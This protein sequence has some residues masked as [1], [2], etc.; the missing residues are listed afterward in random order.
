MWISSTARLAIHAVLRIS[1]AEEHRLVSVEEVAA[2]IGCP[3]NY[4][5]KT[6]Y[7]LAQAGILRSE[8]GRGGGFQLAGRADRL[9]LARIIEPFEPA[10][11]RRCLLGRPMC[12]DA[13]PCPA[14]ERWK[15]VAER[16]KAFFQTT[17]IA[18]LQR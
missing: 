14:H 12:G 3:R 4:L 15:L 2:A 6:L 13:D 5:S 1:E 7:A 18:Q 11:E 17:T 10:A 9:T 16:T 8:R